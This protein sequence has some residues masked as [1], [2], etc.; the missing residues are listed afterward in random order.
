[1]VLRAISALCVYSKFG[2]DPHSP[3]YLCVKFRFFGDLR[4]WA[5][6]LRKIAYSI[7]QS[8]KHPAYLVPR[9]PKLSLRII[10]HLSSPATAS[11]NVLRYQFV[12]HTFRYFPLCVDICMSAWMLTRVEQTVAAAHRDLSSCTHRPTNEPW[13]HTKNWVSLAYCSDENRPPKKNWA[14]IRIFKPAE[15][16][17]P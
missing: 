3:G 12:M 17:S 9:E 1:M 15:R 13:L 5:S 6:P 8:L 2:Q 4:C 16:H 14:W 11:G 10:F 7:T